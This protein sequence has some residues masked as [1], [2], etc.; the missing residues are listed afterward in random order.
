M[1]TNIFYKGTLVIFMILMSLHLSAQNA[2]VKVPGDKDN[3]G[4]HTFRKPMVLQNLKTD[5]TQTKVLA[6]KPNGDTVLKSISSGGSG[7][8]TP[9]L[10]DVLSAGYS[11][12]GYPMSVEAGTSGDITF[13]AAYG[14][15]TIGA[16]NGNTVLRGRAGSLTLQGDAGGLSL[17]GGGSSGF[18]V[19]TYGNST[20]NDG[21]LYLRS[22][23]SEYGRLQIGVNSKLE[24]R[25]VNGIQLQSSGGPYFDFS[26]T[27]SDITARSN[28]PLSLN[29]NGS[30]GI[31]LRG[32]S[33]P[34]RIFGSGGLQLNGTPS[35]TFA[36]YGSIK[37]HDTDTSILEINAPNN[38]SINLNTDEV[39]IDGSGPVIRFASGARIANESSS[40]LTFY[41]NMLFRNATIKGTT[42]ADGLRFV[43][44]TSTAPSSSAASGI[45]G[46]LR[47]S[48]TYLYW[49][50]GTQWL[51]TQMS[52]F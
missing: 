16:T 9:S 37:I 8:D 45:P 46:E 27:T 29:S 13:G 3:Q 4:I 2:G 49:H 15:L 42:G 26:S 28:T 41:G 25:G 51:R 35:I 39:Y 48:G 24:V 19:Q 10:P 44:E 20:V 12:S 5:D 7:G 36:S 32:N 52:T 1:K 11:S 34:V 40:D 6:V 43:V 50:N 31:D 38:G 22:S 17:H 21:I 18:G 47:I 33:G 23:S 14:G 30:G